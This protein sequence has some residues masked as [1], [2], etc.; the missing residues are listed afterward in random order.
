M[1]TFKNIIIVLLIPFFRVTKKME[2]AM[3]YRNKYRVRYYIL[4]FI[5]IADFYIYLNNRN[6]D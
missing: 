4:Y 2:Y 3:T 1:R 5:K 6:Y